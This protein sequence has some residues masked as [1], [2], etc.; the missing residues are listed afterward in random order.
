MKA[1]VAMRSKSNADFKYSFEWPNAA[2][3]VLPLIGDSAA[4]YQKRPQKVISRSFSYIVDEE[5]QRVDI[6]LLLE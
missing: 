5:E 2:T 1:H 6:D 4:M 3:L